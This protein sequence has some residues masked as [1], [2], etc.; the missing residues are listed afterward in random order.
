MDCFDTN[1]KSVFDLRKKNTEA[2]RLPA[3]STLEI[4]YNPLT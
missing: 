2:M 4:E 1:I 3:D